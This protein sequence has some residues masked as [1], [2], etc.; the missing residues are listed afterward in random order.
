MAVGIDEPGVK[1]G[2]NA[3][4][5]VIVS[6]TAGQFPSADREKIQQ[7]KELMGLCIME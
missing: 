4:G 3:K 6:A 7:K 5:L 1:A 2:V